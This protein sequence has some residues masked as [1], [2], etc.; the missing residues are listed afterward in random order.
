M[1]LTHKYWQES[2]DSALIAPLKWIHGAKNPYRS[3]LSLLRSDFRPAFD[4]YKAARLG[5]ATTWL[6]SS[7]IL[8]G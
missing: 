8:M 5:V 6:D 4:L 7:M 1:A 3:S 2:N